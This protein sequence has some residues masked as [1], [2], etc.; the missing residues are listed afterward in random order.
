M[1]EVSL[2]SKYKKVG[3]CRISKSKKVLLVSIFELEP[4]RWFIIDVQKLFELIAGYRF[5]IPI[6]EK[7]V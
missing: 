2:K 4:S 7:E 6:L 5:D 1:G 3:I